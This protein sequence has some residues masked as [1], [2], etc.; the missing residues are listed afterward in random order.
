MY[1]VMVRPG[2]SPVAPVKGWTKTIVGNL[3]VEQPVRSRKTVSA[4]IGFISY[5]T[6]R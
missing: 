5:L 2:Q 3:M 6:I 4:T 1:A